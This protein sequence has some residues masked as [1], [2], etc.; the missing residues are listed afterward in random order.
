MG[1]K[2][3][4]PPGPV[5]EARA[6]ILLGNRDR[7]WSVLTAALEDP[8]AD[9]APLLAL[10]TE[11]LIHRGEWVAAR[12]DLEEALAL[13]DD[14]ASWWNNLSFVL[15][16]LKEY[17]GALE[18][19][20]R[21]L[22]LSVARRG[23]DH[24]KVLRATAD[25][26]W[27]HVALGDLDAAEA[28]LRA[29]A[30]GLADTNEVRWYAQALDQ[31]GIFLLKSRHRAADALECFD[32]RDALEIKASIILGGQVLRE[33]FDPKEKRIFAANRAAAVQ[34]LEGEN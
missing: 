7:A 6:A 18:A 8:D 15:H 1:P 24:P 9:R 3:P 12:A 23:A 2:Q 30:E 17:A 11:I 33:G 16:H 34:A 10:R 32:R 22:A 29:A 14:H 19:R 20:N 13:R 31:L 25:R 4:S 27:S 26:A 5:R 28:D 21:A